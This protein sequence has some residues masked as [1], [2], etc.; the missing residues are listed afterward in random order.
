M[1]IFEDFRLCLLRITLFQ[2]VLTWHVFKLQTIP[3]PL[4]D[5]HWRTLLVEKQFSCYSTGE[6][7]GVDHFIAK[8]TFSKRKHVLFQNTGDAGGVDHLIYNLQS[9][10]TPY[11]DIYF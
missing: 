3:V 7:V 2:F 11:C 9:I 6:A 4:L 8:S 1:Y 5:S 10:A